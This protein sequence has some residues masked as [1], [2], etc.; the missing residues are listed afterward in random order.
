MEKT[1]RS[2]EVLINDKAN[3]VRWLSAVVTSFS[4]TFTAAHLATAHL[5]YV[6]NGRYMFPKATIISTSFIKGPSE[7]KRDYSGDIATSKAL[8][9]SQ[10]F[11]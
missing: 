8:I 9:S 5:M 3:C 6:Y 2:L 1:G 7:P 4:A 10:I 11:C